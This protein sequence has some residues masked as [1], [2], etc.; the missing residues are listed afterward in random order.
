MIYICRVKH[1]KTFGSI[2]FLLAFLL[3]SS[4]TVFGFS[5]TVTE[6]SSKKTNTYKAAS[7]DST[8]YFEEINGSEGFHH[9]LKL[10]YSPS[11]FIYSKTYELGFEKRKRISYINSAHVPDQRI[12]IGQHIFPFHFFW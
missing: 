1:L 11:P 7:T 3:A 4:P 2:F 6:T 9:F 12:R 5:E 10:N 8:I